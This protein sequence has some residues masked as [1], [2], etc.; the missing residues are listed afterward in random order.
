MT[1]VS[2][3]SEVVLTTTLSPVAEA[4][5]GLLQ[6]QPSFLPF[7]NIYL[8]DYFDAFIST[9]TNGRFVPSEFQFVQ[10]QYILTTWPEVICA[11]AAYYII[12]LGGQVVLKNRPPYALHYIFQIHNLFLTTA[13]FLVLILMVEQVAPMIINHGLFY[14]ICDR[15]SWSQ[16]L[17]TLYYL[18]YLI[19]YFEF[20]D[21][22]FL[23]LKHKK[24]TFLHTY[25]HG[26][27]A[28]LC[29]TQLLG[30]TSVSWVPI[31]LNLFVHVIMYWYYFLSSCHIRVWWKQ[32]VTRF[33]IIQFLI[34]LVF[35][36]FATYTFYAE[37]Y[38]DG[39]LPHKGT[40][41]GTQDA[42][43][44]GYLILTSYLFLFISFYIQAYKKAGNKRAAERA[45]AAEKGA[46]KAV[47][48]VLTENTTPEPMVTTT[49]SKP[50]VTKATSR[51][52]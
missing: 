40:C 2:E 51:K 46:E 20:L 32:W 31:T 15:R 24:L 49:G 3:I 28:L 33:Q 4:T 5:E 22:F 9:V 48:K 10:G 11:I 16:E 34:D 39:I 42:A 23:V 7:T 30:Q 12:I 36:Y 43:A 50:G 38:F 27:T 18:N 25:H 44:Y 13:S 29:Y 8:W 14:A 45:L 35:V 6:S 26:A 19:K 37:R 47:E 17:V 21:T 41:Y 1:E 52:A